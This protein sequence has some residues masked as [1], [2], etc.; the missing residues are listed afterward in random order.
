MSAPVPPR[1]KPR[2][3][4]AR[5]KAVAACANHLKD[6]RRAH[7]RPPADVKVRISSTV[8][9]IAPVPDGSCCTSPAQLCAELGEK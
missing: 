2:T 5:Q 4:T 8:R 7:G 6:L 1:R 9:F 3:N